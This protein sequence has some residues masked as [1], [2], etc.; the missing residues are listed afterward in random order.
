MS[1]VPISTGNTAKAIKLE[2]TLGAFLR[3]ERILFPAVNHGDILRV[4]QQMDK[5]IEQ[6]D[7]YNPNSTANA[8]DIIDSL[9]MLIQSVE[10]FSVGQWNN[11]DRKGATGLT[12]DWII[13]EFRNFNKEREW[14]SKLA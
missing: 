12:R 7:N 13:K 4:S 1:F 2:R 14:D 5:V 10:H 3:D 9:S 11:V 8:D 6:L